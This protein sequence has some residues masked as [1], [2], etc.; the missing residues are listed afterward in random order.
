VEAE[1]AEFALELLFVALG[2]RTMCKIEAA[3][4]PFIAFKLMA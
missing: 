1:D 3:E 2:T 4:H